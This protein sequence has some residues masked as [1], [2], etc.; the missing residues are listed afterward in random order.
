MYTAPTGAM[1]GAQPLGQ[2]PP[3]T[4]VDPLAGESPHNTS[5]SSDTKQPVSYWD[6]HLTDNGFGLENMHIKCV[7]FPL[8]M[9]IHASDCVHYRQP[10]PPTAPGESKNEAPH[11]PWACVPRELDD[12]E[13]QAS[14][15]A[16]YHNFP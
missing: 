16:Q 8:S 6:T 14:S 2:Y 15:A 7:S 10:V 4:L 3:P 9:T 11:T 12:D 5:P 1:K 13:S